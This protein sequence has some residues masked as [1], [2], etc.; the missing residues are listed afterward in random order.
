MFVIIENLEIDYTKKIP[1]YECLRNITNIILNALFSLQYI[2][3]NSL[4][5]QKGNWGS[6][7]WCIDHSGSISLFGEASGFGGIL[8]ASLGSREKEDSDYTEQRVRIN[9]SLHILRTLRGLHS[10]WNSA[11]KL[12]EKS[13]K[14]LHLFKSWIKKS[15]L[16]KIQNHRPF[17]TFTWYSNLFHACY[18]ENCQPRY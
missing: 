13:R 10:Q 14:C 2:G 18:L 9:M 8:I 1:Y 12:N 3:K 5:L 7:Q 16:L 17:F 4:S 11:H 15:S 6:Q